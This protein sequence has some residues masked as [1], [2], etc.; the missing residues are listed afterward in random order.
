[1]RFL[2]L[3]ESVGVPSMCQAFIFLP[4]RALV[5][6][7]N[8]TNIQIYKHTTFEL[9]S[10]KTNEIWPCA[11]QQPDQAWYPTRLIKVKALHLQDCLGPL[12]REQ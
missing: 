8:S 10:D 3:S 6:T 1:M 9:H 7:V 4:S 5:G 2:A 12:L 11:Q